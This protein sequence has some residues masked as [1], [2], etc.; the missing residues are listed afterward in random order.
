M[1]ADYYIIKLE[2][3]RQGLSQMDLAKA[4]KLSHK[5]IVAAER[6]KSISAKS[7]KAIRD[8]LGLE[9]RNYGA[10]LHS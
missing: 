7:Y 2:R 9:K 10:S 4:A 1:V 5:T 6:G 8:A 3:F